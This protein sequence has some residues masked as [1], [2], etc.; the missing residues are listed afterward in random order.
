MKITY[1]NLTAKA[2]L[3][4]VVIS[5]CMISTNG[6][7]D[8]S[9]PKG[10]VPIITAVEGNIT[11]YVKVGDKLKKGE[12]LFFVSANDFPVGKI[13]QLKQALAY[14]KKTFERKKRLVKTHSLSVQE[15]DD[16]WMEY[17]DALN[18]LAIAEQQTKCGFYVA[19]F[20]CEVVRCAVPSTSGIA[21]GEPA[22]H[23]KEI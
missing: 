15:L 23:I 14:H 7:S 19:P 22:V 8:D 2:V 16:A 13:K 1:R 21:D 5:L 4:S 17:H 3:I 6:F 12:P 9:L 18:E 20:D 10:A 11:Y